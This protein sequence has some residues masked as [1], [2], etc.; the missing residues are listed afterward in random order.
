M[1]METTTTNSRKVEYNRTR[2]LFKSL[3]SSFSVPPVLTLS[4]WADENR[5]LSPE[6]SA[7]IGR[8]RTDRAPYQRE[9][10][11]AISDPVTETV[12]IKSSA[13]V[14]KSEIVLNAIGYFIDYD[15]APMLYIQPTEAMAK[16][17]SQDR[18]APMIRDCKA[19]TQK[20][21]EAKGRSSDNAIMHKKFPGGQLTLVGANA[22]SGLAS[23]PIRVI[24]MDEVDRFPFSAGSEG[25]PID[26]A[27]KRTNN[28][29]NKKIVIVSTPTN[30]G[31]SRIDKE[32]ENS[33]MEELNVACP[34]CR[35]YQ[36][37][38]WAQLK[39]LHES[40]TNEAEVIGYLCKHCGALGREVEWKRQPIKWVAKYPDN[41]KRRGF[42]LNEFASPWRRWGDMVHDFL[43]AKRNGIEMLRVWHNTALGLSWKEQGNLD[44]N[45]LLMKRRQMYNCNIPAEVLVLTA[46]V[47]V[48]DNR[49][50]YE[51][52]GW[53]LDKKSWG[54][55]YG[56]IMGDPGQIQTWNALD[57]VIFDN[58]EREDGQ[59]LTVSTTCVDSGGHFTS[60]V[61]AYC[62][63]RE[64][65]RVWAIKGRGG[66]GEAFIQRP[67]TRHKSGAWLFNLG[68]DSGKDTLAS[69]LA[70]Q[71]QDRPGY[72]TFPM[73]LDRGYD[74]SYFEGLTAERRVVRTVK[75]Q[76]RI[77]WEK[78]SDHARNE[79]FDIR[80]YATAALE[81][82]N[83]NLA[84]MEERRI[85][86]ADTPQTAPPRPKKKRSSGGVD[87]W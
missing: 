83:P 19:L 45:E 34:H 9:I 55:K 52:V 48:Q 59:K 11:D 74:E 42:H 81:I 21:G 10:M 16:S 18:I 72:C 69:R 7:E 30:E 71:F 76:T 79:P 50:E 32:Y 78:K 64:A 38:E 14:G 70:V 2:K 73:E 62:R 67:K 82:L 4:Q 6:A 68:V 13:Q 1:K 15:P 56:V 47:D 28:Y 3:M 17:F 23:R 66:S 27:R 35:E 61:Y 86:G 5:V 87:I 85:M 12:V 41:K 51:V 65:R 20:V 53:G 31:S 84:K 24:L 63:A 77:S 26:L 22:P 58:Y 33:S 37:Y 54:I 8:W 36:P 44:I 43:N 75:G 25:D 40:G 39:F 57:D 29:W 49:L 60:E 80:N 46:G